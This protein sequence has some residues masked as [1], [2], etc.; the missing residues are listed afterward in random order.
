MKTQDYGSKRMDKALRRFLQRRLDGAVLSLVQAAHEPARG[1][2]D[3]R[4]ALKQART[5]LRILRPQMEDAARRCGE[6]CKMTAA[7]LSA[8]RDAHVMQEGWR[9]IVAGGLVDQGL[10]AAV[11]EGLSGMNGDDQMRQPDLFA[12]AKELSQ[13]RD[14]LLA[15]WALSQPGKL[16][17]KRMTRFR[18]RTLQSWSAAEETGEAAH[19]HAARKA[20]KNWMYGLR[21]VRSDWDRQTRWEH[22]ALKDFTD[23][24]G[25]A[26]DGALLEGWLGKAEILSRP[27]RQAALEAVGVYRDS[28]LLKA[29]EARPFD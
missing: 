7:S 18:K 26:N 24:L 14:E 20:A 29:R 9:E 17:R 11:A 13:S 4:K 1:I 21:V 22:Q 16:Y 8:A 10:G 12:L 19:Y 5:L 23:A 25:N 28:W 27:Q 3:C 15:N 2:H 6:V